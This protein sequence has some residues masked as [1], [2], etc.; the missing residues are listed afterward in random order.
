MT[1]DMYIC[2]RMYIKVRF[3]G[4][5]E[6]AMSKMWGCLAR[7]WHFA[8]KGNKTYIA[9]FKTLLGGVL[10]TFTYICTYGPIFNSKPIHIDLFLTLN[11]FKNKL[12]N[13]YLCN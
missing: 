1:I 8:R 9:Y 5:L 10:Y 2:T 13:M 3:K 4:A 7:F 12:F 6:D 11:L